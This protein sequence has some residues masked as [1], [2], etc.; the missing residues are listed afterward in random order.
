MRHATQQK[1]DRIEIEYPKEEP[2]CYEMA[3]QNKKILPKW[4]QRIL[5]FE[6][7]LNYKNIFTF[8]ILLAIFMVAV[9]PE[10]LYIASVLDRHYI[11]YFSSALPLASTTLQE[12]YYKENNIPYINTA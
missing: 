8:I 11:G 10:L 12:K 3:Q 9:L 4:G 7:C 1:F 6:N 5:H 2:I